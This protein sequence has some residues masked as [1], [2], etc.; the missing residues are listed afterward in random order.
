MRNLPENLVSLLQSDDPPLY[1]VDE[2]L[3]LNIASLS[4]PV[5]PSEDWGRFLNP[6]GET[7]S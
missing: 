6:D 2:T 1:G 4:F 3:A 7:D 5:L